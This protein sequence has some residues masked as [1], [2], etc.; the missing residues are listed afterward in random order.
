MSSIGYARVSTKDQNVDDQVR[1][2][3]E[4]GCVRVFEDV[5]VSGKLASRP[6]WDRCRDRLEPGDTLVITKLD[7]AGR[8]VQHLIQ[9][10]NELA[11]AGVGL[12]VLD[13]GIDT[14]SAM[15]KLFYTILAAFA[16]FERNLIIE[17]THEGLRTAKLNG[18]KAGPKPKLSDKQ[19]QAVREMH[20]GG[21]TIVDIAEV[22]GVSRPVIYRALEV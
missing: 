11:E 16:E 12:R 18:K 13:Q 2:L 22:F 9:L 20:A 21:R 4:A 6:E 8:S 19:R 3:T 15:G 17:R 14:T 7:R 1:R 5:G 10:A